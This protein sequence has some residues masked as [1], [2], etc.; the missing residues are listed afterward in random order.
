MSQAT[1]PIVL[2][3]WPT[4]NGWKISIMLEECGLPYDVR[5]INIGKGEQFT[6]EFLAIAPNNRIPAI[7]D[8]NGPGGKPISIFELGR[9]PAI[10][11][12]QNRAFRRR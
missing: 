6:P 12:P 11:R 7:V 1:D 10:S 8:P 3:Y 9:D 5:M 4:P 2:Y